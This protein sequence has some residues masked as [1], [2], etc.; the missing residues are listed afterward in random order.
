[1]HVT[2]HGEEDKMTTQLL[3]SRTTVHIKT[4]FGVK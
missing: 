2:L 4:T 1:M 3:Y